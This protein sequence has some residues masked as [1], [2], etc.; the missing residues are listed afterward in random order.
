MQYISLAPV[1]PYQSIKR[2]NAIMGK[3]TKAMTTAQATL[4]PPSSFALA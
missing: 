4:D 1:T 3:Q 2:P